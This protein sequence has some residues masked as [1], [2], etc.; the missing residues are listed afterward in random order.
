MKKKG[1]STEKTPLSAR[2]SEKF[3]LDTIKVSPLSIEITGRHEAV[4]W[5]CKSILI[6]SEELIRLETSGPDILIEGKKLS[7]PAYG[8]GGIVISGHL[9]SISYEE[10]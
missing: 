6:Y 7:C 10:N 9:G 3:E 2:I 1:K 8:G 4:I 5:G